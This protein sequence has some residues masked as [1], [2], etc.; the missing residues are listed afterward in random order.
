[1]LCEML[2]CAETITA[3]EATQQ[4]YKKRRTTITVMAELVRVDRSL[5]AQPDSSYALYIYAVYLSSGL[6]G[7]DGNNIRMCR[8]YYMALDRD[9]RVW[10]SIHL[11]QW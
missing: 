3:R 7:A 5:I 10:I 9:R 4:Q 8:E 11:A 1:M 2:C 6:P